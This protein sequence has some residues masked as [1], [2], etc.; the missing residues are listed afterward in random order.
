MVNISLKKNLTVL[1]SMVTLQNE[2]LILSL[3]NISYFAR[4]L[5]TR[6][7]VLIS[8]LVKTKQIKKTKN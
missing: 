2:N 7:M 6:K 5:E 1:V 4:S 8:S 3:G